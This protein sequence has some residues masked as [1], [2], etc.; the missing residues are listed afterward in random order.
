MEVILSVSDLGVRYPQTGTDAVSGLSFDVRPGEFLALLGPSGSGKTTALRAI[1]GFEPIDSGRIELRGETVAGDGVFVRPERR[2]VGFVFQEQALFPHLDVRRNVE[3]GLGALSADEREARAA[4]QLRIFALGHLRDRWPQTISGGERQRVALARSLAPRPSVLLM[5]EPF[6]SLDASLRDALR[7][8]LH[9]L[10]K[11]WGTTVVLVTHDQQ[12]ALCFADR[13][14]V[15]RHGRLEQDGVAEELYKKP[16][17]AFVADFLGD[18]NLLEGDAQGVCA[19][20]VL[21]ELRLDREASGRVMLCLR[22]EHIE[23]TGPREGAPP[24]QVVARE[25]KGHDV[26]F[27]VRYAERIFT[28]QADYRCDFRVGEP[29]RLVP[30][31]AAVVLTSREGDA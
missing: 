13:I 10:L 16:A 23:L 20:T 25:F 15:M 26:T 12:E 8:K 3:F 14:A 19:H 5:D 2:D 29:V 30:K 31:E 24:A 1:A 27:R 6:N 18:T 17:T 28:V 9:A 11:E 21:G 22:P 7:R 4:E